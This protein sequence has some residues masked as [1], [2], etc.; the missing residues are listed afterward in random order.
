MGAFFVSDVFFPD[1]SAS[2]CVM[3]M[4]F[5]LLSLGWYVTVAVLHQPAF[6]NTIQCGFTH[7]SFPPRKGVDSFT[8]F[9]LRLVSIKKAP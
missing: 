5:R 7:P 3:R 1:L 9:V 2:R 6:K 4:I 8:P